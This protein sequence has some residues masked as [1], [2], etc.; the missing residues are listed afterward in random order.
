M[1]VDTQSGQVRGLQR[2]NAHHGTRQFFMAS[3]TRLRERSG[4][5]GS[6]EGSVGPTLRARSMPH[7]ER[8]FTCG[9]DHKDLN[10]D[11]DDDDVHDP[12]RDHAHDRHERKLS[13]F[14]DRGHDH[15]HAHHHD[16]HAHIIMPPTIT[17]ITATESSRPLAIIKCRSYSAYTQYCTMQLLAMTPP[18][19]ALLLPMAV[20]QHHIHPRLRPRQQLPLLPK[21]TIIHRIQ[22]I[23]ICINLQ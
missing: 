1:T 4:I 6:A 22:I 14:D 18:T 5:R 13:L 16:A 17:M 15:H 23:I 9:V 7:L 2:G 8:N 20:Q 19:L 11:H 21:Q 3:A 10:H 12:I